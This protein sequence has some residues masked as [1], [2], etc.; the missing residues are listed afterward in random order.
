M[1]PGRSMRRAFADEGVADIIG[2]MLLV[3]LT[4]SVA[5]GLGVVLMGALPGPSPPV[6]FQLA[7]SLDPVCPWGDGDERL[8]LVHRGGESVAPASLAV[9]VGTTDGDSRLPFDSFNESGDLDGRFEI[10]ERWM[11]HGLLI[12]EGEPVHVEVVEGSGPGR[13]V[14]SAL[15]R[16]SAN[17]CVVAA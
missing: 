16:A 3:G 17:A 11:H 15:L 6:G 5:A 8:V 2:T 10:G 12:M 14:H 1:S 7:V 13:V 4:V 9:L